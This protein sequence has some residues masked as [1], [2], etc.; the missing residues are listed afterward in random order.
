MHT[1]TKADEPLARRARVTPTHLEVTLRDGR[2]IA[3]P[4]SYYPTLE[5]ATPTQRRK[6]TMDPDGYAISWDE[7]GLDLSVES[8]V[9]GRREYVPPP[10]YYER[11]RKWQRA[12]GM[13]LPPGVTWEMV[14][15][16]PRRNW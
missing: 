15:K 10:G 8:I 12:Q 1:S 3:N 14:M 11:L 2:R 9:A 7:I 6:F 4:L 5:S 13:E 16:D